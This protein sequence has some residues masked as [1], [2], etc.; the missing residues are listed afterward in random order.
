MT[1]ICS[2]CA[3][4]K[5]LIA[6]DKVVGIWTDNCGTCDVKQIVCA[7]RDYRYPN[8][9]EVTIEDI[10]IYEVDGGEDGK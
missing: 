1:A 2:D 3:H 6:K 5:G 10:L 4:K 9:R 7:E 8:Q